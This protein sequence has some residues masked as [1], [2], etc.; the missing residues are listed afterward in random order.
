MN[1]VLVVFISSFLHG[2][3]FFVQQKALLSQNYNLEFL[4]RK[5]KN[6]KI[7]NKTRQD[8]LRIS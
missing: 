2:F 3:V 4:E 7:G 5:I 1:K 8:P 6:G